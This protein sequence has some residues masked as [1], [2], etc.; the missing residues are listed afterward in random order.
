VEVT[1]NAVGWW[2]DPGDGSSRLFA[3]TPG[4]RDDPA[5][6]HPYTRQGTYDVIAGVR[7]QATYT[8]S[9]GGVV[10]DSRPLGTATATATEPYAVNEIEA[11]VVG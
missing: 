5:V 4:S 11:V 3:S 8:M 6:E 9:F 2:W 1:A 10:I 7:W